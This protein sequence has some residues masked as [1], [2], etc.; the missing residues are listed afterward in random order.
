MKPSDST[1]N[2]PY[3]VETYRLDDSVGYLIKRVRMI[4]TAA[5]DREMAAYDVS[6]DQWGILIT[7]SKGRGATAAELSREMSCDTGSMTRM[8]DRLE[9]KG[10]VKRTRSEDDRRIVRLALTESGQALVDK[11]PA[12]M[13]KVLNRHLKGFSEGDVEQLKTFLRRIV[14]NAAKDAD[15]EA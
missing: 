12:V 1:P 5:V 2:G 7:M 6:Y 3:H 10:M 11:L 9:A 15:L 13:V 4:F 8:I 14:D